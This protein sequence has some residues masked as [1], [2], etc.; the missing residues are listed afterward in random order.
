MQGRWNRLPQVELCTAKAV[1]IEATRNCNYLPLKDLQEP[2]RKRSP[3]L[4]PQGKYFT[5]ECSL[6]LPSGMASTVHHFRA[7]D[8]LSGIASVDHQLGF[9]HNLAVVVI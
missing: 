2:L 9:A 1:F 4:S 3:A 6:L 7:G 8:A 5:S